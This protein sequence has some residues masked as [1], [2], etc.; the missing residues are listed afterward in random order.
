MRYNLYLQL[1]TLTVV[2]WALL[3]STHLTGMFPTA[4]PRTQNHSATA[5]T[6]PWGHPGARS[7]VDLQT[8]CNQ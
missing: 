2:A 7:P 4:S 1:L 5:L 3:Q 8:T 6:P